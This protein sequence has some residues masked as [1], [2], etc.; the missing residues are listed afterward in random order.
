[1]RPRFRSCHVQSRG[2]AHRTTLFAVGIAVI[3]LEIA[4]RAAQPPAPITLPYANGY[5]T[6][7]NYVTGSVDLPGTGVVGGF[8]NG[9]I[10]MCGVPHHADGS[11]AD[12]RAAW[13]YW[14]T[15]VT[16]PSQLAG[17]KCRDLDL[18]V[19]NANP[20]ALTGPFASCWGSQGPIPMF[21][22]F[23]ERQ[24]PSTR[25]TATSTFSGGTSTART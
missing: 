15:I 6:T 2:F 13:L 18:N 12:V 17:A 16:N 8:S 24:W 19:V 3:F 10:H 14:E 9:T 20:L 5:L 23:K 7:G 11:P 1:M 21:T 4:G 25:S 22:I